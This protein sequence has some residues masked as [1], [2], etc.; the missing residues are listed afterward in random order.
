MASTTCSPRLQRPSPNASPLARRPMRCGTWQAVW[1][2]TFPPK[3]AA[4]WPKRAAWLQDGTAVRLTARL[5]APCIGHGAK[6][7]VLKTLAL[8]KA[9]GDRITWASSKGV[10]INNDGSDKIASPRPRWWAKSVAI[11]GRIRDAGVT[12]RRQLHRMPRHRDTASATDRGCVRHG[13]KRFQRRGWQAHRALARSKGNI[14]H[15]DCRRG[16]CPA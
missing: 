4:T 10:G 8:A 7:V 13:P 12:R 16:R 14:G 1:S 5:K 2:I 6:G 15:L 9:D 11:K 3:S